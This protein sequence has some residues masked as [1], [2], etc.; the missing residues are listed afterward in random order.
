[1]HGLEERIEMTFHAG[2][3]SLIYWVVCYIF[4]PDVS[5]EIKVLSYGIAFIIAA[6]VSIADRLLDL[7]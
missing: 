6:L 1:M 4:W 5:D 7:K 2:L 3:Q